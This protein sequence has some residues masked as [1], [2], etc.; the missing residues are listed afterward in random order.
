MKSKTALIVVTILALIINI[1]A[2]YLI[3]F[4]I[5]FE[6]AY[7]VWLATCV[8]LPFVILAASTIEL[9][10][11]F[12]VNKHQR[13]VFYKDAFYRN[14]EKENKQYVK[15]QESKIINKDIANQ[16]LITE[17]NEILLDKL[18][19]ET[20]KK[21]LEEKLLIENEIKELEDIIFHKID[22]DEL[23]KEK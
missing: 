11:E 1:L 23:A 2:S 4:L 14:R 15:S 21:K 16:F 20:L 7:Q 9:I 17:E 19:N 10:I 5:D 8:I 22:F 18:A 13:N 6:S 12:F 3:V